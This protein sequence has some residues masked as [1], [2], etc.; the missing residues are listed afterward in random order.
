MRT[1]IGEIAATLLQEL[2]RTSI[3]YEDSDLL[4]RIAELAGLSN[5]ARRR[6][7]VLQ[8]IGRDDRFTRDF[9]HMPIGGI[10]RRVRLF[11]LTAPQIPEPPPVELP[12][13]P[14]RR[15]VFIGTLLDLDPHDV[16]PDHA[17]A[18]APLL[19]AAMQ[20][21]TRTQRRRICA[22]HGIG[23]ITHETVPQQAEASERRYVTI[24]NSIR[25][26]MA[27][28]AA[29]IRERLV[30][31]DQ[32]APTEP[33]PGD[34]LFWER[35]DRRGPCWLWQGTISYGSPTFKRNGKKRQARRYVYELCIG[36]I[37]LEH[38]VTT[39]C[40]EA[41]CVRPEHLEAIHASEA[42][43]INPLRE[44]ALP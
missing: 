12:A 28:L 42:F 30:P 44:S 41:R 3:G 27:N 1:R 18:V 26:G 17:A 5:N 35:V 15:R 37:P 29:Y 31:L 20:R 13:D 25:V 14:W 19:P 23:G 2:Q 11:H 39:T 7:L 4:E 38:R 8:A 40:G 9:K 36:P 6:H 43:D 21:L 32:P 24:R 33:L 22:T 34:P 16:T 10:E